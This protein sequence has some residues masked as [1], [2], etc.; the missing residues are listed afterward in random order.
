MPRVHTVQKSQKE[1][2]GIPKGSRY[3]WWQFR[4]GGK[5]R[6]LTMPRGSQLTQSEYFGVIR[7]AA[8]NIEDLN[9]MVDTDDMDSACVDLANALEEAA[10]DI[11]SQG[12]ECYDKQ[13]NMPDSLQ[14]SPTGELLE[15]RAGLCET[16]SSELNSI[17]PANR[18]DDEKEQW[19]DDHEGFVS[20]IIEEATTLI[21][22]CEV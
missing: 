16:A 10:S 6:S 1:F 5:R 7:A 22:D 14:S 12:S 15:E 3:Y 4:H 2:P 13:M 17:D 11:E 20:S 18:W 8:E 9:G 19:T 21:Y